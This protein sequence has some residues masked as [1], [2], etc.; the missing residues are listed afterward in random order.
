MK[1]L[2]TVRFPEREGAYHTLDLPDAKDTAP[3]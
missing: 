1:S 3:S 2:K